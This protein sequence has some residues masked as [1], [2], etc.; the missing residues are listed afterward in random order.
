MS[1][2]RGMITLLDVSQRPFCPITIIL[3]DGG[4]E[5]VEWLV[6]KAEEILTNL[7]EDDSKSGTRAK[8]RVTILA[9]GDME[10]K[11]ENWRDRNVNHY[12]LLDDQWFV[13][14]VQLPKLPA[15]ETVSTTIAYTSPPQRCIS[16]CSGLDSIGNISYGNGIVEFTDFADENMERR[17]WSSNAPKWRIAQ[18][19]LCVEGK[20]A[21]EKCEANGNMVIVSM[22]FC[23]FSLPEDDC[24]VNCP[25]CNE[26]VR[27]V[28]CAF[29]NCRWKWAG[30]KVEPL[31]NP[32]SVHRDKKW[33][34]AD[35]A[36]HL[37]KPNTGGSGKAQ[38]L[39]LTI[40]AEDPK[41]EPLVC[42]LCL[43]PSSKG[44]DIYDCGHRLHKT[45]AL[46]YPPS[47]HSDNES[48]SCPKCFMK[49]LSAKQMGFS[50]FDKP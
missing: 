34:T 16:V 2:K 3:E 39:T 50:N 21:N 25:L 28:T 29:N 7:V 30:R 20:C 42:T 24:K 32:P 13:R 45:C 47:P 5:S 31:P 12:R 27:P 33:Q 4:L 36:Y 44:I 11:R 9:V 18:R 37:F 48:S 49:D 14:T 46:S 10:I 15:G 19:G 41:R 23:S 35:D 40:Y 26:H 38:W 6:E 17:E 22:G 43:I 1:D 8:G